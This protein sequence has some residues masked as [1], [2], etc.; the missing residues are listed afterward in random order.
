MTLSRADVS[1]LLP[2]HL[3]FLTSLPALNPPIVI[4]P[5]PLSDFLLGSNS[6]QKRKKDRNKK[7]ATLGSWLTCLTSSLFDAVLGF[8]SLLFLLR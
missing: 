2:A 4:P 3:S 5:L 6:P 1:F 7:T 8:A